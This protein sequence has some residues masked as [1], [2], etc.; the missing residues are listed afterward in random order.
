MTLPTPLGATDPESRCLAILNPT[1]GL[2]EPISDAWP[3]PT[4][5]PAQRALAKGKLLTLR[6]EAAVGMGAAKMYFFR[7]PN[8][9]TRC[10]L[11]LWVLTTAAPTSIILYENPTLNVAG[12]GTPLAFLNVDR[13]SATAAALLVWDDPTI[14][15][16]GTALWTFVAP[17]LATQLEGQANEAGWLLDQG[18]EYLLRYTDAGA[19]STMTLLVELIE[20]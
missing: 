11:R 2:I 15:A 17:I 7:A 9:A 14:D 13:N 3:L 5:T 10:Q 19:G 8:T 1:T 18:E 12:P 4:G 6:D 20:S 16:D